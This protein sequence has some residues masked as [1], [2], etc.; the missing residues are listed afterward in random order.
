MIGYYIYLVLLFEIF[1]I[2]Y[3]KYEIKWFMDH[4]GWI[5]MFIQLYTLNFVLPL[6]FIGK[7]EKYYS[8]GWPF[9]CLFLIYFGFVTSLTFVAFFLF[10]K[11]RVDKI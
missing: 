1:L 5:C 3:L 9:R 11:L 6:I 8:E 7:Y 10:S 4:I 2:R